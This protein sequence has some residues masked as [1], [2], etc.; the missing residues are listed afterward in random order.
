MDGFTPGDGDHKLQ[1][2]GS[3]AWNGPA[4]THTHTRTHPRT[5]LSRRGTPFQSELLR[6]SIVLA[7]AKAISAGGRHSLLIA[8]DGSVWATGWNE[9][10]QLGDGTFVSKNNF[11]KVIQNDQSLVMKLLLSRGRCIGVF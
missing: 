3:R 1:H 9:Y 11:V 7:G 2:A 6:P 10:G 4:P 5:N 8:Q